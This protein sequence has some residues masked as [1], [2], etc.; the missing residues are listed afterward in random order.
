MSY[1]CNNQYPCKHFTVEYDYIS[2][3]G[4]IS[5]P[6]WRCLKRDDERCVPNCKEYE[7]AV[8]R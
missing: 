1:R 3:A 8:K 2:A 4:G 6:Q 5:N 7:R